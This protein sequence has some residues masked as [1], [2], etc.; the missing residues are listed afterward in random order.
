MMIHPALLEWFNDDK[1]F[2]YILKSQN[3]CY[4]VKEIEQLT[5]LIVVREM[6]GHCDASGKLRNKSRL[7]ELKV[8]V[9][10][11]KSCLYIDDLG[12]PFYFIN[13]QNIDSETDL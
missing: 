2:P 12:F 9:I 7:F 4:F 3:H 13:R 5:I 10:I 1:T 11:L 8:R 6:P